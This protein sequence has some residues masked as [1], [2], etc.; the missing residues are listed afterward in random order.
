MPV[1]LMYVPGVYLMSFL[2][3]L[4]VEQLE[5]AEESRQPKMSSIR[6]RA[7]WFDLENHLRMSSVAERPIST[8]KIDTISK[9]C[10]FS[11]SPEDFHD[12]RSLLGRARAMLHS[13][14]KN[15]RH[16]LQPLDTHQNL[17]RT[18]DN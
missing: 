7:C 12:H 5:S 13:H 16:V 1:M 10:L 15:I 11:L 2:P 4:D 18:F 3:V 6:R 14:R 17:P 9:Q 8:P